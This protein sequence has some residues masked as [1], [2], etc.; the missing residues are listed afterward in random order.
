MT[1]NQNSVSSA[2]A[3]LDDGSP[4]FTSPLSQ[5]TLHFSGVSSGMP[6]RAVCTNSTRGRFCILQS[7]ISIL[8]VLQ[9]QVCIRKAQFPTY[10][11][12]FPFIPGYLAAK[13]K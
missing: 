3:E 7:K 2:S 12:L 5:M 13:K 10:S 1:S 9:S 6:T 11:Q 4:S 8:E